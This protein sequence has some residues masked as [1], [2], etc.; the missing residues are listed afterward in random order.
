MATKKVD[1]PFAVADAFTRM[2]PTI[3]SMSI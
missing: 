3:A 1:G 2:R